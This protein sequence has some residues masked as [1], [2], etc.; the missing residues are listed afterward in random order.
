MVCRRAHRSSWHGRRQ[1]SCCQEPSRSSCYLCQIPFQDRQQRQDTGCPIRSQ[2][3]K[4]VVLL[5]LDGLRTDSPPDGLEC[6][7]A[8]M[9][10]LQDNKKL[11]AE[12]FSNTSPYVIMFGPDKCGA[13][14]KV[15]WSILSARA[16]ANLGIGPLHLQAQEPQDWRV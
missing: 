14:N 4:Y 13:T 6:G 2:A 16:T 10:L 1:R 12:E 11:H 3:P 8:Y 5:M 15:S 9:K 7:G